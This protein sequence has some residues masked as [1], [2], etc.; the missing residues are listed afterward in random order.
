M[1]SEPRENRLRR[2][3]VLPPP[4]SRPHLGLTIAAILAAIAALGFTAGALL[5]W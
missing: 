2:A 1:E 4:A 5:F 3:I